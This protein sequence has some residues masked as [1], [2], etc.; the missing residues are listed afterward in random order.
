MIEKTFFKWPAKM[1]TRIFAYFS[2]GENFVI[3]ESILL[4]FLIQNIKVISE[5]DYFVSEKANSP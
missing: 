2:K 1:V 3:S 5:A 4:N